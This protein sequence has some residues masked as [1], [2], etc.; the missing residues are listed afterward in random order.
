[1]GAGKDHVGQALIV[2]TGIATGE[3]GHDL[4]KVMKGKLPRVSNS[5]IGLIL[6]DKP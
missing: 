1:M 6:R 3:Q 5:A 2:Q 4:L